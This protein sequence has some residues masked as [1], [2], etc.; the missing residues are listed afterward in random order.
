MP[1]NLTD[2]FQK[3]KSVDQFQHLVEAHALLLQI[4]EMIRTARQ[5]SDRKTFQAC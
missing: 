2:P 4:S 5:Q 3:V 1:V